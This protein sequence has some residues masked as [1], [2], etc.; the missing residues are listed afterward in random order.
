MYLYQG[1]LK[2][3]KAIMIRARPITAT[4]NN[5]VIVFTSISNRPTLDLGAELFIT[6]LVSG[7]KKICTHY[8]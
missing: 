4:N 2:P 7:P 8:L 6:D 3:F 1:P 5:L